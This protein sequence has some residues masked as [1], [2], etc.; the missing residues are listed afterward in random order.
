MTGKVPSNE[1]TE[2]YKGILE[3]KGQNVCLTVIHTSR[4][5]TKVGLRILVTNK[6]RVYWPTVNLPLA[7]WP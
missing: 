5:G 6:I 4:T 7:Y 3:H 2:G 1:L